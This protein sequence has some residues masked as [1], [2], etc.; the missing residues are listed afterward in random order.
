MPKPE[1]IKAVEELTSKF[2]EAKSVLL[3]DFKGL[4]VEQISELRTRLRE[5]SIE[6]KVVK[7]TLAKISVESLGISEIADYFEGPVAIAFGVD[8]PIVSIKLIKEFSK[9]TERPSIKAYLFDGQVFTGKEIDQLAELPG[10]DVLIAQ[11]VGTI[12][13]PL[14]N[15]VYSLNNLLQKTVFIINAIKEKKEQEG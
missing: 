14:S 7:N 1:K 9:K 15:L 2:K 5:S 8:D 13:A 11:L 12:A 6:Y 10:K 4:N 3:T